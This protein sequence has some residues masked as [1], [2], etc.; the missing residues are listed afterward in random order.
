MNI[1]SPSLHFTPTTLFCCRSL[2][3]SQALFTKL[4]TFVTILQPL[5]HQ[6]SSSSVIWLIFSLNPHPFFF[7]T[8]IF[9]S[10]Y[11]RWG[12]IPYVTFWK[13]HTTGRKYVT[14]FWILLQ[15]RFPMSPGNLPFAWVLPPCLSP[16]VSGP[17]TV[18][19]PSAADCVQ[20]PEPPHFSCLRS[21]FAFYADKLGFS[22]LVLMTL[23]AG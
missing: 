6:C 16:W 1:Y 19:S 5:S 21:F 13:T 7:S 8:F 3:S 15:F 11:I 18:P 12:Y 23:W 17:D 20:V 2:A 22:T 14:P 4:Q 9:K 10:C